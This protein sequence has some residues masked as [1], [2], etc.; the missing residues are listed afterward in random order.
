MRRL[1]RVLGELH[2]RQEELGSHADDW[3]RE[4]AAAGRWTRVLAARLPAAL[5]QQA[6]LHAELKR[7]EPEVAD[8]PF[9]LAACRRVAGA[10]ERVHGSLEARRA[11]ALA[12]L[13]TAADGGEE[14]AAQD[15]LATHTRE[16]ADGL[17]DLIDVLQALADRLDAE[18]EG[19]ERWTVGDPGAGDPAEWAA[20]SAPA[21]LGTAVRK[22]AW[23]HLP[24]RMRQ[25]LEQYQRDRFL[26][27]Y[28][29]E[30][31]R[32]FRAITGRRGGPEE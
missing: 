28:E 16:A 21:S 10:M 12:R 15:Q 11:R 3:S 4:L 13:G 30:C 2:R 27:A 8:L 26:P 24:P 22:D 25:E 9:V 32:Y 1:V 7:L 20:G 17:R 19:G 6:A 31:A 5:E 23:G 18:Q 29:E 14:Q